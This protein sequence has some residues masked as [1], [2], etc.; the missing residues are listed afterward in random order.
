MAF[1]KAAGEDA[2]ALSMHMAKQK[3]WLKTYFVMAI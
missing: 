1:E 2:V 3:Y